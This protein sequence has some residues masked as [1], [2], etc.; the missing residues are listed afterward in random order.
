MTEREA[1]MSR[2]L[3]IIQGEYREIPRLQLT[4]PQV[5][6]LWNLDAPTCE[7]L[8]DRLRSE[9]ILHLSAGGRYVLADGIVGEA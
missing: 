2:W 5:R 8:L 9:H 3:H 4:K 1:E 7:A 6:R